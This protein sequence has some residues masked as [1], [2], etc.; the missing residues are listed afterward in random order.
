M[1]ADESFNTFHIRAVRT[2][3]LHLRGDVSPDLEELPE[4]ERHQA[5][6]PPIDVSAVQLVRALMS[7]RDRNSITPSLVHSLWASA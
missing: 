5:D 7:E 2:Q 3:C 4:L 6:L 1:I